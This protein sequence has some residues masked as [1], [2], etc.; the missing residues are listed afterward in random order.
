MIAFSQERLNSQQGAKL[1][2]VYTSKAKT[3]IDGRHIKPKDFSGKPAGVA[4]L[5]C[6]D[7]ANIKKAYESIGITVKRITNGSRTS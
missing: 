5:V 1:V 2:L 3:K 7:D 6:T 4:T